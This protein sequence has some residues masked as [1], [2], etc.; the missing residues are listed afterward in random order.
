MLLLLAFPAVAGVL[1]AVDICDGL[2]KL[3]PVL[4]KIS[5]KLVNYI[6]FFSLLISGKN[7]KNKW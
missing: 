2:D 1:A 7:I 6:F 4:P 3:L 5:K